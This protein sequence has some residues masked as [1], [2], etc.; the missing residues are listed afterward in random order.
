MAG[1]LLQDLHR[2]FIHWSDRIKFPDD[3]NNPSVL[4]L[5]PLESSPSDFR[6]RMSV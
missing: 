6:T 5:K 4:N 3:K 2:I 1:I